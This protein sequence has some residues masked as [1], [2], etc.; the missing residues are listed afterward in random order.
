MLMPGAMHTNISSALRDGFNQ[1][2][3]A[4]MRRTMGDDHASALVDINKLARMCVQLCSDDAINFNGAT[5]TVDNG[6]TCF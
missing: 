4:S 2:G 6:V 1:D 5:I 3:M